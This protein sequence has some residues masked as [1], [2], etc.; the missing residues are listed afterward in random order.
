MKK[1]FDSNYHYIVPE[2]SS[3]TKFTLSSEPKPVLEFKEA[4]AAGFETRPVVLG[5]ISY[6]M[7]GKNAREAEAD[8]KALSLLPS[9]LTVYGELL[10][11]LKEAGATSIQI[12]EPILVL[13]QPASLAESFKTA[14]GGLAKSGLAITI[15]TYFGRITENLDMVKALPIDALHVDL[16]R[17]RGAPEQIDAVI[18]AIKSSNLK[19]SLGLVSGRNIW[20]CDVE[21]AIAIA[22]KAIDALGSDR[23]IVATSS[24]LLHTP[25]TL[26]SE[27]KLSAEVRDWFAFATEKCYEVAA[28][29]K[30]ASGQADSVKDLLEANKKSIAARR[31]FEKKSDA[32]V[33]E[34][35]AAVKQDMYNRR[36]K[37]PVRIAAQQKAV[38]LPKFPT[39]TIGSFPQTKEI[40]QAR[41]KFTKGEIT[42]EEYDK[43][44]ASEIEHA[45]KFQER[46]GLDVL[47]HGEPERNDM[48]Q[49]SKL[50]FHNF[51]G[52]KALTIGHAVL[53]RE[54]GRFCLH[55]KCMGPVL[56]V[57]IRA[58]TYHCVRRLSA[59]GH[60]SPMVFL[61]PDAVQAACQGYADRARDHPQLVFSSYRCVPRNA[62]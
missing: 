13:D 49:V 33:R 7:L 37:F 51:S 25:V 34:R 20:K 17:A 6:L 57:A 55:R 16:D 28:I 53:W 43:F 31:E 47:V 59:K 18:P 23:V 29:A 46:I 2:L 11:Q 41:A 27:S 36:G 30:A 61:C 39:T 62:I 9:L 54:A 35:L 50:R 19:L 32:T 38:P 10:G 44:I 56:R 26:A 8:F 45:I 52:M 5:P 21:A 22:K 60:D 58:P 12:D 42:S 4:K 40:R 15:A 3:A 14:Y 1:W 48:V 24:S